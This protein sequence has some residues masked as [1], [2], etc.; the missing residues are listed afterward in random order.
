MGQDRDPAALL[1]GIYEIGR[2]FTSQ[3]AIKE[4]VNRKVTAI[5]GREPDFGLTVRRELG[6]VFVEKPAPV[7]TQK[8]PQPTDPTAPPTEPPAV[9]EPPQQAPAEPQGTMEEEQPTDQEQK[10]IDEAEAALTGWWDKRGIHKLLQDAAATGELEGKSA[11]CLFV[12][13]LLMAEGVV[14]T[15]KTIEDALDR[16]YVRHPCEG[17]AG[18]YTHQASMQPLGIVQCSDDDPLADEPTGDVVEVCY[19]DGDVTIIRQFT[20]ESD[21][22]WQAPLGGNLLVH[23]MSVAPLITEQVRSQQR[24]LNEALTLLRRN[25]HVNALGEVT[26]IGIEPPSKEASQIDPLTGKKLLV[27]D[28]LAVGAGARNFVYPALVQDAD[29]NAILDQAGKP[30]I[31]QA[32][33]HVRPPTLPDVLI[34]NRDAAYQGILKECQQMYALIAGDATA[35]GESRVQARA[36][37][38]GSLLDTA[39]Q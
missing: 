18:V 25:G 37:F 23:Q 11:L 34:A 9:P 28:T 35:S 15:A 6:L 29:G 27:P 22:T 1:G 30:T 8:P 24:L 38:E 5:I 19:T 12:P 7:A 14:P 13:P 26:M 4:V 10:L 2:L 17:E 36:D 33:V 31:M 16:I 21:Q 32:Q 20:A 3:N 39:A